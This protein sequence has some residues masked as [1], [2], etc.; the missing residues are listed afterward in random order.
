MKSRG[1]TATRMS[2]SSGGGCERLDRLPY[3]LGCH[4]LEC[5]KSE[6]LGVR[7]EGVGLGVRGAF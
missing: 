5:V 6:G 2:V 7:N 3:R 4:L 1:A